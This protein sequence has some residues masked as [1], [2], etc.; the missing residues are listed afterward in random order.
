M[1]EK[2]DLDAAIRDYTEAIELDSNYAKA[3]NGRGMAYRKRRS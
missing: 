3:Y 2:G 1:L